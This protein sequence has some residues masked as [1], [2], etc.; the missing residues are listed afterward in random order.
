[1][2]KLL[3][4]AVMNV[5]NL[6]LNFQALWDEGI[7]EIRSETYRRPLQGKWH[8]ISY[9]S[10]FSNSFETMHVLYNGLFS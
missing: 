4:Q 8:T 7:Q 5:L 10:S 6:I 2:V 3:K 9:Q 1:M